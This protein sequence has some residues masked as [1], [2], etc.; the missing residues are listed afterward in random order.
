MT[1][2]LHAP[3]YVILALNST[4]DI[5]IVVHMFQKSNWCSELWGSMKCGF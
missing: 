1:E 5:W 2:F 4:Y 3:K